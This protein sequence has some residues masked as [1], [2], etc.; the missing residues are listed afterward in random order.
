M[1]EENLKSLLRYLTKKWQLSDIRPLVKLP[2]L[3]TPTS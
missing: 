3:N 2:P 1:L